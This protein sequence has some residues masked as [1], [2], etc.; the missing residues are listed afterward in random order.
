MIN[1]TKTYLPPIE[2]YQS[3]LQ[4]IWDRVWVT[5][6]GELVIELE[7]KLKAHLGL[8]NLWFTNNGTI[9][10][11]MSLKSLEITGEVITTPFSY[12]ATCNAII[13]ED[14]KP[15][16]VDINANDFCINADLI[17]N[18]ITPKTQAIMATH[19]YGFP[20]DVDKIEQI[21]KKHNLK[22][23]YDG[24]HAF[25]VK[26]NNQSLL[27]FGDISTCSF[28]ATKVFHTVEGGAIIV[29]DDALNE[30]TF[31]QRQFGH[32]GDEYRMV[33]VNAKNSE[34]HA[35]MGLC[36][37]PKVNEIIAYRKMVFDWYDQSLNFDKL[38]KPYT[39]FQIEYNYAYY[40][41][42]FESESVL[43]NVVKALNE[44]SIFPRRY[45]FPALNT[46]SFVD[47]AHCPV[48]EDFSLR[49]LSLP[50]FVGIEQS[51]VKQIVEIINQ[52]L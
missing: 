38:F 51:Q 14:C 1:V 3:Y 32:K 20:C 4:S 33:G 11:Q 48:A 21:A 40:P 13:W 42:V 49:V 43:L 6:N 26:F 37:L 27:S 25:G 52:N 47:G 5:N 31:W 34:L 44:K 36:N 22:V 2:E 12:V 50:L 39:T 30:K 46:L 35:A 17:E 45:F 9:P 7:Q 41:V 23:I 28:H 16:F 24:A 18:A 29:N 19:V 8:K 10:L 15:I